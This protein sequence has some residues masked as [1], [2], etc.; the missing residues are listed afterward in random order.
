MSVEDSPVRDSSASKG[1]ECVSKES[2]FEL[3]MKETVG[4]KWGRT[5]NR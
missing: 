2:G 1:R 4:V 5:V 3:L